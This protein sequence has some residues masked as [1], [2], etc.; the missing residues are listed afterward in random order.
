MDR[1]LKMLAC[2]AALGLLS[3]PVGANGASTEVAPV[4]GQRAITLG[5]VTGL[6]SIRH[7]KAG[8]GVRLLE[9]DGS[10]SV[11]E[12]PVALFLVVTNNGTSDL[13][14]Q[15][16]R[17]PHGVDHVR[18]LSETACGVDVDVEVDGPREPNP[19]K[20]IPKPIPRV[21]QLCFLTANGQLLS[22]LQFSDGVAKRAG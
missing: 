10:A 3:S 17:L 20:P 6:H 14:E 22:N 16:W 2:A 1:A 21:F 9:A 19:G 7:K 13:Q 15:V 5:M 18:K 12:D 8:L 4:D 11:A